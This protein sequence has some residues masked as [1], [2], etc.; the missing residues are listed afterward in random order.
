VVEVIVY[1]TFSVF[2]GNVTGDFTVGGTLTAANITNTGNLNFGDNDK[3]IFGAGSD[4]QIYH[5]GLNSYIQDSGTGDL[6]LSSS[7]AHR[8]RTDQ[9]QINNAANTEEIISGVANGAVT[10]R[11]DG[12]SKFSTTAT[13]VNIT[14]T[15]T[16]DGL[17]V[18]GTLTVNGT[19][20]QI[21]TDNNGFITSKQSLDVATAGGRFIGKSN[22]GELGQ[23][24]IEQTATGADG[25]YIRF[26][27]SPSGSTSPTERLR[28]DSSGN[29]GIANSSPERA[30]H[31]GSSSIAAGTGLFQQIQTAGNNMY[32]GIG[33]NNSAYIQANGEFRVATGGYADRVTVDSSGNVGIGTSS[34]SGKLQV[35]T[36][37]TAANL[38]VNS[39][40]STSALASRISLG[41]STSAARFTFG[42]LGGGGEIAYLGSEGSFPLYFQTA[43]TERLRIDSSGNVGIGTSAP[44]G[45]KLEIFTGS[46]AVNGLKISRYTPGNYYST[47]RQDNHGLAIDVG[48]GGTVSERVAITPNGITFNGDT[49][50]ANALDDYEEGTW[51]PVLGRWT[52][53]PVFSGSPYV[54]NGKYVKIGRLLH[55]NFYIQWATSSVTSIGSGGWTISGLPFGSFSTSDGN[56][57]SVGYFY[58]GI[59]NK[60]EAA[61]GD[62]SRFQVNYSSGKMDMYSVNATSAGTSGSWI[63]FSASGTLHLNI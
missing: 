23:I 43:G 28:I 4:L 32:V 5:D 20:G 39:D 60:G 21:T 3:A 13:G 53:D 18:D 10:L 38:Y 19:G 12:S 6:I 17:S 50:A 57:L 44:S 55:V 52:T 36:S 35:E 26:S 62:S 7:T 22:R 16:S 29:V 2:S 25:G 33:T 49:A 61:T 45:A 37:G 8:V 31:I 30:L 51:T 1:D 63:I 11:Y 48:T 34:P 40:I 42:L 24:A 54:V 14:G 47:L 9:F 59:G 15:I 46:T 27:T 56:F 58:D 41:N